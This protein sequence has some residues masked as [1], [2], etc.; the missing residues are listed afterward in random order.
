MKSPVPRE[1]GPIRVGG[2]QQRIEAPQD[3]IRSALSDQLHVRA[4]QV[5]LI[6]SSY[7]LELGEQ[8]SASARFP[9]IPEERDETTERSAFR[10]PFLITTGPA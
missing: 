10:A 1:K 3:A 5:P 8:T 7:S 6:L 9:R 4:F 2:R